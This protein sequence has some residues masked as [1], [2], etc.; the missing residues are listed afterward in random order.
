MKHYF[1]QHP[2]VV[3]K[4]IN[5]WARALS[6]VKLLDGWQDKFGDLKGAERWSRAD[7]TGLIGGWELIPFHSQK[8]GITQKVNECEWLR[9]C[10]RESL[11]AALRLK[12]KILFVATKHG[13]EL[14]LELIPGE[15]SSRKLNNGG[16]SVVTLMYRKYNATTEI[17]AIPYQI[18]SAPRKF[19]N[20]EIFAAVENMR[21]SH[22]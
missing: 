12:P 7:E 19:R 18:F 13:A 10:A 9:E 22:K 17:I 5:W 16:N 14:L 3:G 11:R 8:D 6:S 21:R 1:K 20:T 15:Y 2:I 4:R